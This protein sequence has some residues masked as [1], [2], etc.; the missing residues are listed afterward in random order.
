MIS[1]DVLCCFSF[2]GYSMIFLP[3]TGTRGLS[4]VCL[5]QAMGKEWRP[6]VTSPNILRRRAATFGCNSIESFLKFH[7]KNTPG[8]RTALWQ[9]CS[10]SI[11]RPGEQNEI[12]W[13]NDTSHH[14]SESRET[15]CTMR[16]RFWRLLMLLFAALQIAYGQEKWGT[17]KTQSASKC[18]HHISGLPGPKE[19]S[20]IVMALTALTALALP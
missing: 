16:A 19:A 12:S 3:W 10:A 11:M 14:T 13:L 1:C 17:T 2:L 20:K 18:V 8:P 7:P 15:A 4:Y 5:S 9:V 6:H